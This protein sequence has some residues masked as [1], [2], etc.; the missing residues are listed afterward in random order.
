MARTTQL[1][2][3]ELIGHF[4]QGTPDVEQI[5]ALL[6][7]D[8]VQVIADALSAPGRKEPAGRRRSSP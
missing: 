1:T 6:R 2:D 5:E 3:A 7:T 4:Q 8:S